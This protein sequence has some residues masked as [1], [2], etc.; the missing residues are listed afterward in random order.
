MIY[1]YDNDNGSQPLRLDL[2]LCIPSEDNLD[3]GLKA[4]KRLGRGAQGM[5][6]RDIT[7]QRDIMRQRYNEIKIYNEIEK[8][9]E[10]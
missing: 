8:Y 3:E 5:R 7:R 1:G 4:G 10:I 9:N 2:L 6:Q